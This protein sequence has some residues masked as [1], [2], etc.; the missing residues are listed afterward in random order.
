MF[1]PR[2]KV[3]PKTFLGCC[4]LAGPI[5]ME[6]VCSV[7]VCLLCA[8]AGRYKRHGWSINIG[9]GITLEISVLDSSYLFS[10]FTW[11]LRY[12]KPIHCLDN[13]YISSLLGIWF[14]TCLKIFNIWYIRVFIRHAQLCYISLFEYMSQVESDSILMLSIGFQLSWLHF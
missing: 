13:L 1:V 4:C 14:W 12:L 7:G 6:C 9:L 5:L 2:A 3:I 11:I 8:V 10:R